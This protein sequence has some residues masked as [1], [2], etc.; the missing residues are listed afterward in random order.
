MSYKRKDI[1]KYETFDYYSIKPNDINEL[2]KK[3]K[4]FFEELLINKS[5]YVLCFMEL[6]DEAIGNKGIW[7]Y[8]KMPN[9]DPILDFKY[10]IQFNGIISEYKIPRGEYSLHYGISKISINDYAQHYT[11]FN[12]LSNIYFIIVDEFKIS[13]VDNVIRKLI[14]EAVNCRKNMRALPDFFKLFEDSDLNNICTII[15]CSDDE[16]Y[17]IIKILYKDGD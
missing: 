6:D 5:L 1:I 11:F 16:E 10:E 8:Y 12:D 17:K 7:D 9:D 4:N 15:K 13:R 2:I 14:D 3:D